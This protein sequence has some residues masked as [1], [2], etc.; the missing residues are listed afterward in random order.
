MDEYLDKL[1]SLIEI[2]ICGDHLENEVEWA[3][4]IRASRVC[5][6]PLGDTH[7]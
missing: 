7:H 1:S 2:P 3:K 5:C 4:N 6:N